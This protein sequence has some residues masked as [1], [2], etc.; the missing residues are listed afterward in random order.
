MSESV[1]Y[2]RLAIDELSLLLPQRQI[3]LLEPVLEVR[4]AEEGFGWIEMEGEPLPV[5]CLSQQLALL[6]PPPPQRQICALLD[7]PGGLF[8]LLCDELDLMGSLHSVPLPPAMHLPGTPISGLARY[9]Q[10][11]FCITSAQA[12]GDYVERL[13]L[14]GYG[15]RGI[16]P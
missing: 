13:L 4:Y 8:G 2:A 1:E 3:E 9:K 14:Q 11:V 15:V 5:Y 10:R 16:S 7:R 6:H 12:L